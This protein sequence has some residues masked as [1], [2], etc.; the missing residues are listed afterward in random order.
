MPDADA[1]TTPIVNVSETVTGLAPST[2]Y[3]FRVVATN[4]KGPGTSGDQ[5]F[6]TSADPAAP[7]PASPEAPS[8]SP[9]APSGGE[10]GS[11]HPANGKQIKL[12]TVEIKGRKILATSSRKTLYSLSAETGGKFICTKASGCVAVWH[13]LLVPKGATAIGPVKLGTIQRPEGGRQV[14]YHGRPLYTFAQD[15]KPG[16]VNG[17]GLKDVGTWHAVTIGK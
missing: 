2:T 8:P 13:P 5:T 6:T 17:Q 10:S 14:T 4:S 9:G 3:H 11:G 15:T 7:P 1:G 16:Q 12:T